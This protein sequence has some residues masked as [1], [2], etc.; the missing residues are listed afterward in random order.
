MGTHVWLATHL[1]LDTETLPTIKPQVIEKLSASIS[2]GR[3]RRPHVRLVAQTGRPLFRSDQR[4][5]EVNAL[6]HGLRK[7]RPQATSKAPTGA[8]ICGNSGHDAQIPLET[9]LAE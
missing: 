2:K 1:Y 5:H 4:S 6:A 9:R 3:R 7:T 8:G